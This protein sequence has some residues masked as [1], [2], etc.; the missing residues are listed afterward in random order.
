MQYRMMFYP[1]RYLADVMLFALVSYLY[2]VSSVKDA[3]D[4]IHA[5]KKMANMENTP[6]D[7]REQLIKFIDLHSDMKQLC[8]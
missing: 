4:D 2:A 5:L 1:I 3:I 7:I 8:E 6:L